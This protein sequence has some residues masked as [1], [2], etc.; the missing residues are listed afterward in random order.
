MHHQQ[1]RIALDQRHTAF[2]AEIHIGFVN[3]HHA[4]GVCLQKSYDLRPRQRPARGGVGVGDQNGF[5][6]RL[7]VGGIQRK[8]LFQR[9]H[10]VFHAPKPTPHLVKPIGDIRAGQRTAGVT[11]S[12]NGKAEQL[13]AAVAA[14]HIFGR[15]AET[16]RNGPAQRSRCRIAVQA[17]VFHLGAVH[18]FQHPRAGCKRAFVGVQL[19]ICFSLRLLAGGIGFQRAQAWGKESTHNGSPSFFGIFSAS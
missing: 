11:E 12:A 1:V 18:G 14:N 10:M 8:I 9:D 7:I 17:Q 19:D 2:A 4:V 13:V 6:Q 3:D 15:K 16:I 5:A